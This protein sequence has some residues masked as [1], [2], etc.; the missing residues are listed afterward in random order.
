ML[1][2]EIHCI[3]CFALYYLCENSMTVLGCAVGVKDGFHME[4]GLLSPFLV[5]HA[6]VSINH[7]VCR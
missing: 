2:F 7:D 4:V 6:D 1:D 5:R 3:H